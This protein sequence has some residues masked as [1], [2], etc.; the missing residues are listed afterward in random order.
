MFSN[1]TFEN[2]IFALGVLVFILLITGTVLY[3]FYLVLRYMGYT[4]K[5]AINIITLNIEK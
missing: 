4:K 3:G 5:E 2:F 1:F